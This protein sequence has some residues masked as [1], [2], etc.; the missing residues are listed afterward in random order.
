MKGTVKTKTL[1]KGS[2]CP[3]CNA[4][5]LIPIIYGMPGRELMEQSERGEIELG[6]CVVNQ[7]LDQER[8][9]F[10]SG[11][12]ELTCP[13]CQGRFFGDRSRNNP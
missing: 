7:V 3:T 1:R 6:G 10:V 9:I 12:S 5:K 8:F 2:R 13:K 11:D 4:G